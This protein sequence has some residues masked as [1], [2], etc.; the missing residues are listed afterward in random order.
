M[1]MQQ[2]PGSLPP[3]WTTRNYAR[4]TKR[5]ESLQYPQTLKETRN[6]YFCVTKNYRLMFLS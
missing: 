2:L 1:K 6:S 3:G 5:V 4:P